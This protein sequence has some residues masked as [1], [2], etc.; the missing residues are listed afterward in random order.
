MLRGRENDTKEI[1]HAGSCCFDWANHRSQGQEWSDWL[2]ASDTFRTLA[3]GVLQAP[4]PEVRLR[5]DAAVV[6]SKPAQRAA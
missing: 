3:A 6:V 5:E 4:M 1:R 2:G